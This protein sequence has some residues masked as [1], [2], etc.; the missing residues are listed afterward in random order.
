M[1][2]KFFHIITMGCQMNVYDSEQMERLLAA[3]GYRPAEHMDKA[4]LIIVNTCTIREKPEHK[5]YSQLGRLVRLK[6]RNS[7]VIL[8]VGGCVAQQEGQR[9]LRRAPHIDIVFGTSTISRLP[10]LV[11]KVEKE[12]IRIVSV[13]DGFPQAPRI[14]EPADF[15]CGRVTAFV[16]IMTGCDNY[17]TYCVVPYVRGREKS[18]EPARILEEIRRLVKTGVRE[19]TLLGQNVNSFGKINGQGMDFPALLNAVAKVDGLMRIRFTTS[20]PKDL[21][22]GLIDAFSKVTK[23]TPHIHLPVQSGSDRILKKM[24]RGYTRDDYLHKVEALRK[25]CPDIS[26]TSDIIVGFPGETME[27]FNQ[28]ME[29]VR[30]VAFDN[31][32][33]FKYS[34]RPEVPSS[35]FSHKVEEEEKK[36]RLARVLQ[37]QSE[38]TVKKHKALEGTIQ[39]VL[40]EGISK[41][42]D[43]QVTGH[44][45]CKRIVNFSGDSALIGQI[46]P[47]RIVEG[48]SH[49]LLGQL[50]KDGGGG[51]GKE[52]GIL[53]AA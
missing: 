33:A 38:M 40:V 8:A 43:N 37:R 35:K 4:D 51:S 29:L 44:T 1:K 28:T 7:R 17:C 47:I 36:V 52:G 6:R 53:H 27:D 48:F 32:F 3:E 45:P 41:M 25:V 24:N 10:S 20:H 5:V 23:L 9:M 19:V 13:E 42:G 22:E 50:E 46:V 2:M 30:I 21:S 49:S 16:T 34:D 18:R 12:K 39:E 11:A 14:I 26:I 15:H 31:L